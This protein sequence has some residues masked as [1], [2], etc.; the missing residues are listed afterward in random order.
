M[1][2]CG[3][4]L[5]AI[6]VLFGFFYW[7]L[8]WINKEDH[9]KIPTWITYIVTAFTVLSA[10]A[11][12][13]LPATF[14]FFLLWLVSYLSPDTLGATSLSCLF[15][16]SIFTSLGLFFYSVFAEGFFTGLTKHLGLPYLAAKVPEAIITG[17]LLVYLSALIHP[18]IEIS[19]NIA[20]MIGVINALLSYFLDLKI[21]D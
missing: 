9:E 19:F 8:H 5:I 2:F 6:T 21:K 12:L 16:L 7:L 11:V 18:K 1:I 10:M 17:V 20:I 3:T 15:S 13:S 14:I 4:I